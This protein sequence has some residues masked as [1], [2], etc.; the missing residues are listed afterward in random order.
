MSTPQESYLV[1]L[2]GSGI[3]AS[4]TPPLHEFAADRAG[5]R[6][7]YRPIDLDTLG[8]SQRAAG[9]LPIGE[10][11][12]WGFDFGFNAF[13]ITFPYKQ[14]VLEHLDEVSDDA[15]RLGAVNT[16]VAQEGRLLGYNTDVSG[17]TSALSQGLAP[18]PG[19][20]RTV[21]QLGVGGAGS[22]TAAALLSLGTR[23]LN[24]FDLDAQRAIAKAQ[25]LAEL[26]P[27]A[28]VRA[29]TED[30]LAAV[31]AA[32]TGLVNATPIGMHHHPG[33]PLPLDYLHP[34]L[35]VFDVIYLPQNT[36]LI[37]KAR[38]IGCRVLPGGLMAVGQAADAFEL[39]T[40]IRPN[41]TDLLA[42]FETL[43]VAR[44]NQLP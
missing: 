29:V 43:L 10:L 21:T 4:L 1:G 6:Y 44:G 31:L 11:L 33:A 3:T 26:Y 17:F 28:T 20:L 24:L 9:A 25:Q 35:W 12:H 18:A 23:T 39:I 8:P 37:Q 30:E 5:L 7:L 14:A 40:G 2:L 32:S 16:V 38:S 36:P 13:N 34:Q 15:A 19:D 27:G 22:A 42:H 41:V